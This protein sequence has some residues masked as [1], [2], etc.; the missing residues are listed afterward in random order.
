MAA[1]ALSNALLSPFSP[2]SKPISSQPNFS[3]LKCPNTRSHP[4]P[5]LRKTR[6]L[7]TF[8]SSDA[9]NAPQGDTPIELRYP[10]FPTVMDINQIREILPHRFPFLLVD[11]V[12][13]YNPGV[14]AVAIKNVTIND[15]F[16]P[17]HFPERPIMPGVLMVE[18][19]AQ[20]GGLVMLQPEVGGSRENFFFAGIDKVRFRKPVIAGDT[21]VMRMTLTKLQKRFG[22]AKM[23]GKA[24]VGGDVVC[25]GEFL[26][27]M[28]S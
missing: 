5:P 15:N 14:S 11:R 13:E 4:I 1:S 27:A 6:S 8:C 10:A 2:P 24:F 20:V 12:I 17:G 26:M 3:L 25:E 21:L 9:A 19:M 7:T 16:F 23:E 22:I 18:A 28:G